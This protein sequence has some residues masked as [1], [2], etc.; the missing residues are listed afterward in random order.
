MR[1]IAADECRHAELAWAV[2]AWARPRLTSHERRLIDEAM[3]A[4]IDAIACVDR[5]TARLLGP[6]WR[7]AA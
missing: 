6:A 2:H 4:A 7:P 5:R 3:A 1:S